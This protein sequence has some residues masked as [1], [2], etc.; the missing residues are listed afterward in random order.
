MG[1]VKDMK[2]ITGIL[3]KKRLFAIC[4]TIAFA[5]L[6]VFNLSG[7]TGNNNIEESAAIPEEEILTEEGAGDENTTSIDIPT[8]SD[9]DKMVAVSVENLGR[10]NP[11]LPPGENVVKIP[12]DTL[13]YDVLPPSE[14]PAP[15]PDARKVATTKV[16]GIMY[17]KS[18][19]SAIL[20]VEG[21]DYL[22]RSGD[23]I[24]G[25]KVLAIDK[26]LVTVQ[27]GANIYKAGVGQIVEDSENAVK[28]NQIA[29]LSKKFGGNK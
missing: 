8:D 28:Y 19:P 29:N 4:C 2:N 3:M 10:A 7:C 23:V 16:S 17:D 14:S 25:Y 5:F 21:L 13:K 6:L 11:F 27:V 12:Q 15:D 22:V 9:T 20:N 18:S 26:S 1:F 24:N